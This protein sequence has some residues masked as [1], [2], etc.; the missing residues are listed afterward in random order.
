MALDMDSVKDFIGQ[1]S[2]NNITRLDRMF[3]QADVTIHSQVHGPER[4]DK[5]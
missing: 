3:V 4:Q 1:S 2:K 5:N